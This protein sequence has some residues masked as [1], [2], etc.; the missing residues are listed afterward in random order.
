MSG[1]TVL[2]IP[3]SN[4]GAYNWVRARLSESVQWIEIDQ[5]EL[6]EGKL[7]ILPGNS[8]WN[9]MQKFL[10]KHGNKL[11]KALVSR[12][13]SQSKTLAICSAAHMLSREIF[14]FEDTERIFGLAWFDMEIRPINELLSQKNF[15]ETNRISKK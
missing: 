14:E 2:K 12:Y 3:G 8:S 10:S 13:N 5:L 1:I 4:F 6:A 15:A 9:S 11:K 7:L